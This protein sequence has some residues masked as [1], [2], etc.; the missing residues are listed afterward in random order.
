MNDRDLLELAA[1]AEGRH[2]PYDN[3]GI[4]SAWVGDADNGHWW[5]PLTDDG[6][7]LRLAMKL[8]LS[9]NV[10]FGGCQIVVRRK[11]YGVGPEVEVVINGDLP[12]ATLS[13]TA[14][15]RAIVLAAAEIG[16]AM[17]CS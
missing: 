14:Y 9:M 13:G 1:K 15:R 8:Y 2:P 12:G 5:N 6:D 4:F 3:N 17:P 7:A 10:G 11:S 16:S